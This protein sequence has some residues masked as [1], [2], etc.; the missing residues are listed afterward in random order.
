MKLN[1]KILLAV[2]SSFLFLLVMV[3]LALFLVKNNEVNELSSRI[4]SAGDSSSSDSEMIGDDSSLCPSSTCQEMY[5]FVD[6]GFDISIEF[7]LTWTGVLTTNIQP[8]F[9]Y[10]PIT[11]V[12][13]QDYLYTLTKG[14]SELKFEQILAAI[15]GF[16]NGLSE[17]EYE[18]VEVSSDLLRYRSIGAPGW[19][20]GER[21]DCSEISGEIIDLTAFT[22][23]VSPFTNFANNFAGDVTLV[24]SSSADIAE[25]DQIVISAIN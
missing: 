8:E 24:S 16:P 23:C 4:E 7:P 18:I 1:I 10:D 12:V 3:L 25:A 21:L 11:G 2:L 15:D 22:Y 9:V 13:I 17:D 6:D 14:S 19:G 5:T 20:Y